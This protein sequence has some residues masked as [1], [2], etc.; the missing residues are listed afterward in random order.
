MDDPN[1]WPLYTYSTSSEGW[2][3]VFDAGDSIQTHST[4]TTSSTSWDAHLQ[5]SVD[6][7]FYGSQLTTRPIQYEDDVSN[8]EVELPLEEIPQHLDLPGYPEPNIAGQTAQSLPGHVSALDRT[9]MGI[10]DA[11]LF[12][13]PSPLAH[14]VSEVLETLQTMIT[15]FSSKLPL[16]TA[17]PNKLVGRDKERFQCFLCGNNNPKLNTA[18]GTFTRHLSTVHKILEHKWRC[19]KCHRTFLRRDRMR[20]HLKDVHDMAGQTQSELEQAKLTFPAPTSCPVCLNSVEANWIEFY[21]HLKGDC[22]RPRQKAASV[23]GDQ[24]RRGTN[25]TGMALSLATT[26]RAQHGQR[27]PCMRAWS[28]WESHQ[29]W[30]F[31]VK[32]SREHLNLSS[33]VTTPNPNNLDFRNM[34]EPGVTQVPCLHNSLIIL[35]MEPRSNP[36]NFDISLAALLNLTVFITQWAAAFDADMYQDLTV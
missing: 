36:L 26:T 23:I 27:L 2:N 5:D 24:S 15:I 11:S 20:N 32:S 10:P 4:D 18:W 34:P 13:V 25:A 1:Q 3:G 19:T 35:P 14:E 6:T 12:C 16:S 17:S 33:A 9:A 8:M 28:T 21:K 29:D 22:S 31:L 7:T 30:I